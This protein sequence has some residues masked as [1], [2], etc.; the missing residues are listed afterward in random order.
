MLLSP[1]QIAMPYSFLVIGQLFEFF[2]H[3]RRGDEDF[4]FLQSLGLFDLIL[5]PALAFF[6][7][8]DC[9]KERF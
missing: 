5:E 1:V 4:L 3:G 7:G 6:L 8:L 9:I 2:F